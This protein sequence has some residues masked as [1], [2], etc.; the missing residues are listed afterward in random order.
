MMNI[1]MSANDSVYHGVELAIYSTL[2]HNKNINWFIFTMD[3]GLR[4]DDNN[5]AIDYHGLSQWQ[6]EKLSK[7]VKYL[8]PNSNI[9][10]IDGFNYYCEYLSG[11][12]NEFSHFTPYAALRLIADKALPN[13]NTLLYFDC[14]V[15]TMGNF[16]SMYNNCAQ[17]K[18]IS[19]FA[20]YAEDAFGGEGEMVSGVMFF[21]LD[22]VRK[23]NFLE[24]ARYNFKVNEYIYPDQMA[25]RDS[26]TIAKLPAVYGYMWD[27]RKTAVEPIILHFTN[28]LGPK[29][30]RKENNGPYYFY[31]VFHEFKYVLD[32]LRLLDSIH[33]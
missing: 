3:I 14:D 9:T 13:V 1:M 27:F 19:A 21:N 33:I 26:G 12:V 31:Q 16:E 10:F 8:D 30:Y 20:V 24:Q 17:Q 2:T 29:I 28:E 5:I 4:D 32:G 6:K 23:N 15:A 18:D 7:I 22:T 11:G 25:L